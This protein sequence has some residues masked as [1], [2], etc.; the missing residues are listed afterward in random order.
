MD[1]YVRSSVL[2]VI[3]VCCS[4]RTN[5]I[6]M[7]RDEVRKLGVDREGRR[8]GRCDPWDLIDGIGKPL[9][10]GL[11]TT[12]HTPDGVRQRFRT[13]VD[14]CSER[15]L[16]QVHDGT[17]DDEVFRELILKVS[18]E[19]RLTLHRERALVLQFDIDVCAGL[20]DGGVKNGNRSHGVVHGV[21]DILYEG[22]TSGGDGDTSARD[23]HRA[24]AY[25]AAVG[26][27]VLTGE[28]E[29]VFLRHL[30]CD[31]QRRVVEFREAVLAY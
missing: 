28:A 12:V 15:T 8:S 26:A 7:T 18:A 24:E 3:D 27:F 11:P 22:S 4:H 16:A 10:L 1:V 9:H 17:A 19:E 31:Y 2:E 20:Q 21:V 29:F 14:F 6:G 13:R 23:I 5:V 25:L 30:L